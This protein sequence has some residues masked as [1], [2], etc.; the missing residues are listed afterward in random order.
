MLS[1]PTHHC[2]RYLISHSPST[3]EFREIFDCSMFIMLSLRQLNTELEGQINY[4]M[5][6]SDNCPFVDAS[7]YLFVKL[8]L[9]CSCRLCSLRDCGV[10][11]Y[12]TCSNIVWPV[13]IIVSYSAIE[14]C[15]WTLIIQNW[16]F[17]RYL[18]PVSSHGTKYALL[19]INLNIRFVACSYDMVS[20]EMLP[21]HLWEK[22]LCGSWII[23]F[24]Q[25]VCWS[26]MIRRLLASGRVLRRTLLR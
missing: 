18:I 19:P 8:R 13:Q 22:L 1:S 23:N 14:G 17:Q 2:V 24:P 5:L 26:P 9:Y 16:N 21:K 12:D 6:K 10:Q 7:I 4:T 20:C 15:K 3:G 25:V 11:Q